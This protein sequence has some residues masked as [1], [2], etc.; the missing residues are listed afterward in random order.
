M[1]GKRIINSNDAGGACTTNT[2]DYPITN[3]AY[4]KMSSAADEKDTYNGAA[5]DVNFNVAGKFGNAGEFNGSSSYVTT[6]LDFSNLTDYSISMWVY[7]DAD[8]TT[9]FAGTMNSTAKNGIYIGWVDSINSNS[10]SIRFIER[11]SSTTASQIHSTDA[12]TPG[13]WLNIVVV[14]DGN[15]NFLYVNGT[16]QGSTTNAGITHTVDFTIGRGGAYNSLLLDGKIDQVRI[17]SSALNASQVASLYNEVYCVPTIVPTDHFET[18]LYTGNGGTQSITSL[19]F[20]PDFTWV[21]T[22]SLQSGNILRSTGMDSTYIL[23]SNS[24]A[25]LNTA[26][27]TGGRL[28][29]D[30]NGFTV[31]DVSNNGYGVNGTNN[32]QVAWNW[33]AGGPAVSNP[34][35]TLTSTISDNV[36]AGFSIVKYTGDGSSSATIGHGLGKKPAMVMTKMSEQNGGA[37]STSQWMVYHKDLT[38]NVSGDNPYNLYFSTGTEFDLTAFGTYDNITTDVIPVTRTSASTAHNNNNLSTYIAYCF[39]EV[40]GFSRMGSYKGN[41]STTG[42]TIVTGFRPA[43]IMFKPTSATGYWYILDNKRSTTNPRN[44]GLF[45]NDSLN[46]ITNTSYNVDFN[47]DGFQLKNNTIGFNQSGQTYIF[48]AFAEE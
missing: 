43:W 19:N 14:R 12:Y 22:R 28:Q 6:S 30:S 9:F 39:A 40:D 35:G 29:L 48:M 44:E 20:A 42:P 4:Y 3:L 27:P 36:D 25:A 5:T 37:S 21:K 10:N 23:S 31:R 34:N 1:L 24:T 2:N 15:T 18:V 33:K 13:Q 46:E 8:V 38:G 47:S 45:P 11:D 17:F 16:A 41:G 7:K 32:T 26:Q